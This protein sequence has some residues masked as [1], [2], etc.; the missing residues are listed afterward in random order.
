[1]QGVWRSKVDKKQDKNAIEP[2]GEPRHGVGRGRK[3]RAKQGSSARCRRRA[4]G[5]EGNGYG[6]GTALMTACLLAYVRVWRWTRMK[7][8]EVMRQREE[9]VR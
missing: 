1:M 7:G 6:N 3:S 9:K 2:P 8:P 5:C 4:E